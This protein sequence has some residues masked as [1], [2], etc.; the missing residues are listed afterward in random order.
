M[1]KYWDDVKQRFREGWIYKFYLQINQRRLKNEKN[2][3][4]S[5]QEVKD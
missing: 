1:S 4:K 5:S 2:K 3:E